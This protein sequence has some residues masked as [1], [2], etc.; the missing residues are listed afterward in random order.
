MLDYFFIPSHFRCIFC[1]SS[2]EQL[3]FRQRYFNEVQRI[4]WFLEV[5]KMPSGFLACLGGIFKHMLLSLLLQLN[6]VCVAI[7]FFSTTVFRLNPFCLP[8]DS[9]NFDDNH[10]C[11]NN[12]LQTFALHVV[13]RIVTINII[14]NIKVRV[15]AVRLR[16]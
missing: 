16:V 15:V 4:H 8:S 11:C 3:W 5:L 13:D 9:A 12:I 10:N 6:F 1:T 2:I 14:Y 7:Q